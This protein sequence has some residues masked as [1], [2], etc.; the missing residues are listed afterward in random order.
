V[1]KM[2]VFIYVWDL[3]PRVCMLLTNDRPSDPLLQFL[4]SCGRRII[5]TALLTFDPSSSGSP[6][7]AC[8]VVD[9]MVK[10]HPQLSYSELNQDE[11]EIEMN[12]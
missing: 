12:V 11:D 4:G 6:I 5:S 7:H 1:I 10:F 3:N 2:R 8:R 9:F